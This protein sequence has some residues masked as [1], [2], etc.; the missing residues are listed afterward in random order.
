MPRYGLPNPTKGV[1]NLSRGSRSDIK[2]TNP[3]ST[4]KGFSVPGAAPKI[5]P[6]YGYAPHKMGAKTLKVKTS[7]KPSM[8]K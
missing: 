7:G 5:T 3:A 8:G 4:K 2:A 6:D 1:T